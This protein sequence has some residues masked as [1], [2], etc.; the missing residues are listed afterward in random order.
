VCLLQLVQ[1]ADIPEPPLFTATHSWE[2]GSVPA[3]SF[4]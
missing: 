2:E 4:F 1:D 3:E